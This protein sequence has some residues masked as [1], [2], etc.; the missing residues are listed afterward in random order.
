MYWFSLKNVFCL[1]IFNM[2]VPRF[3]FSVCWVSVSRVSVNGEMDFGLTV[4]RLLCFR[5]LGF[6]DLGFGDFGFQDVG[7]GFVPKTGPWG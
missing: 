1:I 3:L 7:C 6:R 5:D 2:H 4:F